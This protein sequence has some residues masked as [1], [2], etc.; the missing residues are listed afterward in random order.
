MR[1][2]MPDAMKAN[3]SAKDEDEKLTAYHKLLSK[4]AIHNDYWVSL[5]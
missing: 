1:Q 5:S 3:G 4:L 2:E